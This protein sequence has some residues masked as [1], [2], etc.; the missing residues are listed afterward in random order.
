MKKK[1]L[2]ILGAGSSIARGIPS[3][4]ALDRHM[5]E[6]GQNWALSSGFPDYYDVLRREIGTYYQSGPSGARPSL[7]F[8]KVLG[9]MVALSH[10]M[11]PAP[12]GDTLRQVACNG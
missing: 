5:G 1:L 9:E 11:E 7:N 8:E 3:V 12:W 10:W 2:V 6:W 4:Q